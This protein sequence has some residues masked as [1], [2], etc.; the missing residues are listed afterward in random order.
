MCNLG[1]VHL[2][3]GDN[4]GAEA[5]FRDALR[6]DPNLAEAH[7][8]L[9]ALLQ[10]N[11]RA[12]EAQFHRD[13]A[14]RHKPLRIETAPQVKL[15]VLVLSCAGYGNVPIENLL[16]RATITRLK[17][18]VEYATEHD[19]A[20][21]PDYDVVFNAVGDADLMPA[22]HWQEHVH[23]L[24]QSVINTPSHVAR[25]RRDR[26]YPLLEDI[27]GI[28]VPRVIRQT[29]GA[30]ASGLNLPTLVRPLGAHG[31]QGLKL[32]T[33]REGI[34]P[35]DAYL[36]EYH[37][38][39]SADGFF[40]KYRVIFVDRVPFPYHLA[41]SHHWMVHYFSADM[42]EA[43]WKRSEEAQFLADPAAVLG[44][45][46]MAALSSIGHRLDLDYAGI[47]FGV[48]PDGSVLV[49]EAN[50]TMASHLDDCPVLFDYKH[51]A[52]PRIFN[53]FQGMLKAKA[54]SARKHTR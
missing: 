50:A 4:L 7:Q 27:P 24:G 49:F 21:L 23:R 16:P 26:L 22:G 42:Q 14:F 35:G 31:G 10:D 53:A 43:A 12:A 33:S 45:R 20:A 25:T 17:L 51:Q 40:R 8:N 11:G 34:P 1:T 15:R 32:T 37:D 52:I 44:H 41:I 47:D 3:A 6:H 2:R 30:D 46:A 54:A 29:N 48:L 36:T 39:R 28:V 5:W 19:W 13:H 38:Y 18:F 9:A